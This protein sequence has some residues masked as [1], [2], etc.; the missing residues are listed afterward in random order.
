VPF[1]A[2]HDATFSVSYGETDAQILLAR[3]GKVPN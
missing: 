2:P 3:V 1:A